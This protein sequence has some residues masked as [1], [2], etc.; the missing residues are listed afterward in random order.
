M[1]AGLPPFYDRSRQVM[2][3]KILE[4]PLAPPPFM[5]AEA[6]DLCSKLL[7]REPTARL[8]YRGVEEIQAHPFWKGLDWAALQRMEIAPPW[9]P[10]VTGEADTRNIASEFTAEPAAVTPSPMHSRLRDITGATP[11]SFTDFTFTHNSV[12]DGQTYQVRD[13]DEDDDTSELARDSGA[14]VAAGGGAG[15]RAAS[16]DTPAEGGD[17]PSG[18][19]DDGGMVMGSLEGVKP[20]TGK[21]A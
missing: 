14:A 10:A 11:P 12:L 17:R 2:Y 20:P 9:K 7:V 3:R 8:G 1:I 19:A 21:A 15:G 16:D 4:E 18:D 5:S 6:A 13:D